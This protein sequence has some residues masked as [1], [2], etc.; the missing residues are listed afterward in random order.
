MALPANVAYWRD[1]CLR[2]LA[3]N[4]WAERKTGEA[5]THSRGSRVGN[6]GRVYFGLFEQQIEFG[7]QRLI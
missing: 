1:G 2:R 5:W 7:W 3:D 4:D 6:S